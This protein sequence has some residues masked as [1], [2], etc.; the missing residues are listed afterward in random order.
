M[1]EQND[2]EKVI[3]LLYDY[4]AD[5]F[6]ENKDLDY[7]LYAV[8]ETLD[9]REDYIDSLETRIKELEKER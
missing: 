9:A 8:N 4:V 7:K 6:D 2:V 3:D 5:L 1:I